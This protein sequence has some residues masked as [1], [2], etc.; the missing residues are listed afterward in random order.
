MLI[1]ILLIGE[2][3]QVRVQIHIESIGNFKA[4]SM[5]RLTLLVFPQSYSLLSR[6]G[7]RHGHLFR[8]ILVSIL[9]VGVSEGPNIALQA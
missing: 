2:T 8:R 3:T 7:L 6:L 5:V 9:R 4:G 1:W